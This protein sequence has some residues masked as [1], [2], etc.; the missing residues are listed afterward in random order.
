MTAKGD[1]D[2][3]DIDE[4]R[5]DAI[6]ERA[7]PVE[8]VEAPGHHR[9]VNRHF[10]RPPLSGLASLSGRGSSNRPEGAAAVIAG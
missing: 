6:M 9:G 5:F 10:G 1:E 3:F 8:L 4:D 7:E 2:E